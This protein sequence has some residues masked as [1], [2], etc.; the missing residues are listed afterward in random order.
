MSAQPRNL[1][2]VPAEDDNPIKWSIPSTIEFLL[3]EKQTK[4]SNLND[5]LFNTP[6]E[7]SQKLD[8]TNTG[9][10]TSGQLYGRN[11]DFI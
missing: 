7:A 4:R 2:Q 3:D 8:G 1:D 11:I 5:V 10:D 6:F 9:K